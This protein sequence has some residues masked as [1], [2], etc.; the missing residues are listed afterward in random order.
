MATDNLAFLLFDIKRFT[1]AITGK[2]IIVT[3]SPRNTNPIQAVIHL[4]CAIL[5][6]YIDT[7]VATNGKI[8]PS[9]KAIKL[10]ASSESFI[11]FFKLKFEKISCSVGASITSINGIIE[12]NIFH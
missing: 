7:N 2:V 11:L 6:P 9:D 3:S 1:I 4:I 10:T 8:N 5:K 12:I